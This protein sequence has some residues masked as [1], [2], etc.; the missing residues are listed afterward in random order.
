MY[1]VF[2]ITDSKAKKFL[3]ETFFIYQ[4]SLILTKQLEINS[5]IVI[6]EHVHCSALNYQVD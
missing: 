1:L 6:N 4:Q 2:Y 3:L 5:Y